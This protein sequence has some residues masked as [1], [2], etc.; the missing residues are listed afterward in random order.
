MTDS[1]KPV[2]E[3]TCE[4]RH[5]PWRA[6]AAIVSAAIVAVIGLLGSDIYV[7]YNA[8][9]AA[10]KVASELNTHIEVQ[11]E[12]DKHVAAT[13]DRIESQIETSETK[14]LHAIAGGE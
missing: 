8:E 12:H 1:D 9:A 13:L 7:G 11:V 2:T 10:G 14:I 4:N 5:R 3:K 6:F